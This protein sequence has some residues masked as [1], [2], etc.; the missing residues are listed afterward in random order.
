MTSFELDIVDEK[1]RAGV[2]FLARIT[3]ELRRAIAFEKSRK[4][5]T[6]QMLADKIHTSRAVINREIQGIENISARRIG[7]LFWAIGWEP[8]FEAKK[9]PDGDNGCMSSKEALQEQASPAP[10][11]K[12]GQVK[13]EPDSTIVKLLENIIRQQNPAPTPMS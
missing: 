12:A 9:I 5:L 4:K 8:H 7:E 2:A 3:N 11:N 6:Q 1:S 13:S 10:T